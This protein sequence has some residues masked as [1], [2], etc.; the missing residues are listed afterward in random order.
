MATSTQ[1]PPL[2]TV[3]GSLN[4][5]LVSYVPHHPLPGET[6]TS[7]RF[8]VSPGGKGANQAVACAKLSRPR[9]HSDNSSSTTTTTN[10]NTNT[11]TN[12][13]I[14]AR[15]R[16]LGAVGADT[17][18]TQLL[19][20]LTKYGIDT[21]SITP[22]PNLKTGLAII[23]VDEPTGQNRIV[24]S[25]EANHS[26]LP[27]TYQLP[28]PSPF[29]HPPPSLLIMQLEIPL[30]T[31]LAALSTATTLRIPVLLNPA[32]AQE[33]PL[34]AYA[35]LA[36]LVVNETEASILAGVPESS[37]DTE[38]GL[39]AVADTFLARGVRNVVVTLGGRGVYYRSSGD[40]DGDGDGKKGLLPAEKANVVDTTAAGDTFV[41]RY[42]L[43]VVSGHFDIVDAVRK[44]NRA[45]AKTVERL[46]AQESIPWRDEL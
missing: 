16:M 26:L 5:D 45:A 24:L 13:D 28:S 6:L 2:I 1:Q 30:P 36:H 4:M 32:P 9:P 33:L 21:T 42:A 12:N 38:A 14:T 23:I 22:S 35:D 29:G 31:V 8:A 15:V 27:S 46:G 20:N 19:T 43:E 34:S 40:G 44:A 3:L 37:L 11:N 25:P 17:Y 39:D 7:T 41:G 10:T 18:G